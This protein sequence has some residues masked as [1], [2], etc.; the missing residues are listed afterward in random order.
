MTANLIEFI[1]LKKLN[2]HALNLQLFHVQFLTLHTIN[3]ENPP[4]L[5]LAFACSQLMEVKLIQQLQPKNPQK[6]PKH[7]T[8]PKKQTPQKNC[9]KKLHNNNYTPNPDS[10]IKKN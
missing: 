8:Q 2:K 6:Q 3:R 9:P 10:P 5:S 1:K 4:K 7:K